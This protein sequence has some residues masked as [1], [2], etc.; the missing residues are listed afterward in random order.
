MGEREDWCLGGIEIGLD[1]SRV[2]SLWGESGVSL[3]KFLLVFL[4]D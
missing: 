2:E 3:S 1:G 4:F